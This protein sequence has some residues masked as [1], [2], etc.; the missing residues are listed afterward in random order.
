[1][2]IPVDVEQRI[3]SLINERLQIQIASSGQDLFDDG[4]LDSLS[5]IDTLV[6]LEE[7]FSIKIPLDRIDLNDFRS[8][9]KIAVFVSSQA[10]S[11]TETVVG[12]HST[13]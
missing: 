9:S 11:K 8:I 13:V 4:I 5:F 6:A 2:T 12:K 7:E 10:H 1:M 3:Q